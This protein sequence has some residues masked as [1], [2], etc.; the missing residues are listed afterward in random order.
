METQNQ[1]PL[2][3]AIQAQCSRPGIKFVPDLAFYSTVGINRKRFGA[4]VR[5]D[6]E[7][8]LRESIVL[9]KFFGV[10]PTSLLPKQID[11]IEAA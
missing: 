7:I 6:A 10:E 1:T 3:K 4:L 2:A 5:G 11:L 9:G 8:T